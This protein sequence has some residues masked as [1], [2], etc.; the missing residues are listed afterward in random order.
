M[1]HDHLPVPWPGVPRIVVIPNA[2]EPAQA[3]RTRPLKQA[4]PGAGPGG[5]L[6]HAQRCRQA[7]QALQGLELVAYR[8]REDLELQ[9]RVA[10][11]QMLLQACI[12]GDGSDQQ[13]LS[14]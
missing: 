4:A 5:V 10:D 7:Q 1:H 8:L 11:D 12:K 14:Q 6:G 2:V 9:R 3:R 13:R